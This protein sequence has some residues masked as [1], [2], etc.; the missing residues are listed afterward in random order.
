MVPGKETLQLYQ[1]RWYGTKQRNT[2]TV[3]VPLVWYQARKHCSCISVAG[4]V[5]GKETLQLHQCHWYDTRQ[6]NTAAASVPL[7]WYQARKHCSC[8]SAAGMVPG[9][10]TLQVHRCRW[11]GTRQ[12]N[13]ADAS[14]PLVW[15]QAA[16]H[17][18][19]ISA[20][21]MVPSSETLQYPLHGRCNA[22]NGSAN[23]TISALAVSRCQLFILS[24]SSLAGPLYRTEKYIWR[25]SNIKFWHQT[26]VTEKGRES[27]T[28]IFKTHIKCCT[29]WGYQTG[30]HD[31]ISTG[32]ANNN[33]RKVSLYTNRSFVTVVA[34][35]NKPTPSQIWQ[36]QTR[37]LPHV[38]LSTTLIISFT[39]TLY[40]LWYSFSSDLHPQFFI[41]TTRLSIMQI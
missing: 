1:C 23:R 18:S 26:K 10:E 4:M 30:D 16:K 38:C 27:N 41:P 17:C 28:C 14:V 6:G 24:R 12:R 29:F 7:V 13:T 34:E 35:T 31:R 33:T 3:S 37:S 32:I 19:C 5:P 36:V 25:F 22:R 20:A 39:L 11:Y 8:I 9:S 15:Y 21:G 40:P 2:A